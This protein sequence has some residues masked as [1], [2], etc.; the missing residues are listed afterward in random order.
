MRTATGN[1]ARPLIERLEGRQLLSASPSLKARP[2]PIENVIGQYVGGYQFTDGE[3]GALVIAVLTQHGASFSGTYAQVGG[4]TA[5][6]TGTVNR[7][8][9]VHFVYHGI[10]VKFSG[11]GAGAMDTAGTTLAATF[12]TREAGYRLP[13]GFLVT[14]Q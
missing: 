1:L 8:G 11:Q 7:K 14:R 5:R 13:G 2:T 6:M 10:G 4:P 9:I 12:I 3:T